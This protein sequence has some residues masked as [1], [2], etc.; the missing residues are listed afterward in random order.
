MNDMT[1]SISSL[2]K[3][4]GQNNVMQ[5]YIQDAAT[6]KVSEKQ[7]AEVKQAQ[8]ASKSSRVEIPLRDVELKFVPDSESKKV[9]VYVVDKTSKNLVRTIP[10][11]EIDKMT[12]GE[13]LEIIA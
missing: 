10:P 8:P 11:E 3:N 4:Y 13:L 1:I 9:T 12:V 6:E 5:Q 7:P 2:D